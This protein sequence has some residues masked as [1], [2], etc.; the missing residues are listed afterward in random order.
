[1]KSL[2]NR[3]F[4]AQAEEQIRQGNNVLIRPEGNS[5]VPMLRGGSDVVELAPV[6][7]ENIKRGTV[8][9]Y[10]Y[11]GNYMIHRIMKVGKDGLCDILGDGNIRPEMVPSADII[12]VMRSIRHAD[13]RT[14]GCDS[15][16][17]KF[18]S[19]LWMTLR[20]VRRYILGIMRRINY[21]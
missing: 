19:W 17:W 14:I 11:R 10:N 18:R 21:F 9:F 15:P 3:I 2:P 4:F 16:G 8:V 12:A 7:P 13:G 6:K 20:P 5:M 1:M